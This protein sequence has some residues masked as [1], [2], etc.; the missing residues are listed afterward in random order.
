VWALEVEQM[1]EF[2]AAAVEEPFENRYETVAENG[3][4]RFANA[5]LDHAVDVV[6]EAAEQHEWHEDEPQQQRAVE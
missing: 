3:P 6:A 5:L 2:V 4:R 1:F